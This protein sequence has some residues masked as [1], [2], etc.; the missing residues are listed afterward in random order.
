[1][2][3]TIRPKTMGIIVRHNKFKWALRVYSQSPRTFGYFC[4]DSKSSNNLK[5]PLLTNRDTR[6]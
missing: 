6:Y 5:Y 1:M 2:N 3:I 4:C